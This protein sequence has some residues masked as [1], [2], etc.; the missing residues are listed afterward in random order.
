MFLGDLLH[1]SPMQQAALFVL[2]CKRWNTVKPKH[3]NKQ[4]NINN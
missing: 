3:F 4:I 2:I 1:L